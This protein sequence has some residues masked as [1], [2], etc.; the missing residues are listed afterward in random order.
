MKS[1]VHLTCKSITIVLV[2]LVLAA[3]SGSGET[4]RLTRQADQF[5]AEGRLAE[6]VLTYRQGLISHPDDLDLLSGLGMALAAQGRGRSAAEV[7]NRAATLKPEE[8]SPKNTL[9][10]LITRPEDGLSLNLAWISGSTDSEPVGAAAAAGKIFVSYADGHLSSLDQTSGQL[11][12]DIQ[13]P[14]ALV[15]SP[16]A[17]AGQ[18]WVGAENGSVLVYATGSGQSMGSYLT[19]GAVYAAPVLGPVLAYC[20]SSDGSLY[21]IDRA[22][23]KLVWKALI[24]EAMHA[25]P[26]V[27]G[28]S[29]YVGSND[30]RL[31]GFD[32]VGGERIWP[33]GIPTQGAIESV[34]SLADG[35]I[36]FGS[37]DGR[38]YALDA[39][40]GGEY[41]RFSTPD[42][43]YARPLVLDE[44][45]IVASSG[46]ELDSIRYSDGAPSWR[47]PFDKPITDAPVLFKDR[48]YLVTLGDPRLFAVEARTGKRLGELNT[49]DWITRGPFLAGSDLILVGKDG[50]VFLYR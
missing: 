34:P 8:A 25:S 43:V 18:V 30:G 45:V 36:F 46:R 33:Y 47:L 28:Q 42:A 48:L 1:I 3:C 26:L 9:A 23:L 20:A 29:V 16:A 24:G 10:G 35:R 39:E 49:G 11:L 44:Q 14:A 6:A 31:Y 7:L 37:D 50:A 17:D 2:C 32:A 22:T 4:A 40:T 27:N 19:A 38:V 13:A 15:S 5:M 21:A 12:W 41:W